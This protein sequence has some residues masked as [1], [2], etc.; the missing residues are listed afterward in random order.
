MSRTAGCTPFAISIISDY[1]PQVSYITLTH[2]TVKVFL[3]LLNREYPLLY[4]SHYG[5]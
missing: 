1:F 2:W 3:Y 5:V 4:C